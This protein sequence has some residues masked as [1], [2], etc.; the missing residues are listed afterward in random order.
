MQPSV[1]VPLGPREEGILAWTDAAGVSR[2]VAAVVCLPG[3]SFVYTRCKV[4]EVVWS[5]LL[6]REDHQIGMQELLA[7]PLLLATFGDRLRMK[8]LTVAIDSQGVLGSM[9]SGRAGAADMNLSVGQTWLQA[10]E[11]GVGINFVR[12]EPASNLAD[13]PT[14]DHF[15]Y[16]NQL[17]AVEV[18][19]RWPAWVYELWHMP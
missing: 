6:P 7:V 10:A 19:P 17:G 1:D 9:V 4:P 18:P 5:Q 12:V 2:W 15:E 11:L 14:R 16:L 13:G 3:G 8:L